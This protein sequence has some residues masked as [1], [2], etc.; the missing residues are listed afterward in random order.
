MEYWGIGR[1]ELALVTGKGSETI[2]NW[3]AEGT[4]YRAPT[5]EVL[6][7]LA[8]IHLT[9]LRWQEEEQHLPTHFR[10]MYELIRSRKQLSKVEAVVSKSD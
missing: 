9:W 3:L 6:D 5:Q 10:A 4:K 8:F 7:K 2:K 1:D